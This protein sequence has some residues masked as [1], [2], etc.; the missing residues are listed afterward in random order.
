MRLRFRWRGHAALEH[1]LREHRPQ[2]NSEFR[3][4]VVARLTPRRRPP[5]GRRAVAAAMTIGLAAAFAVT[6]GAGYARNVAGDSVKTVVHLA[7][8]GRTHRSY[9]MSPAADQYGCKEY[10][11]PHGQNIPPAGQTPPGTNPRSGQNPDGF[12]M[13]GNP[14]GGDVNVIDLGSGTVFGPYPGG[15]VIKYTQGKGT[16]PNEKK[17]GGNGQSQAVYTHITGNGDFM[18]VLVGTTTGQTCY[19][20]PPPK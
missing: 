9:A 10:V 6:G 17:I 7:T 3:D 19:V 16:T 13:I 18:V 5:W 1:E 14:G 11:N 8:H 20:P 2:P 4:D 12:Y 15:T